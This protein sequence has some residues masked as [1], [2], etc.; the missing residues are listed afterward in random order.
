LGY[1]LHINACQWHPDV[2]MNVSIRATTVREW[3]YDDTGNLE[4]SVIRGTKKHQG[5]PGGFIEGAGGK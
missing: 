1:R 3:T 5:A 4:D 2:V